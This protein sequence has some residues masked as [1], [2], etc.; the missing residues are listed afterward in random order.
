MLGCFSRKVNWIVLRIISDEANETASTDFNKF[1]S[2]YKLKS[3][4]LIKSAINAVS[5]SNFYNSFSFWEDLVLNIC[6]Y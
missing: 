5:K 1:L 2:E 6:N 4:D 3:F